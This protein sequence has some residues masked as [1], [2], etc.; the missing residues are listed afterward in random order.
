MNIS[1]YFGNLSSNQTFM[2]LEVENVFHLR[3]GFL[4]K[5]LRTKWVGSV[6]WIRSTPDSGMPI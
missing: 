5:R 1:G 6:S 4:W 3:S 2:L